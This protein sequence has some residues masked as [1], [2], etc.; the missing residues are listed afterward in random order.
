VVIEVTGLELI[1]AVMEGL[2]KQGV[3]VVLGERVVTWPA[4]PEHLDG[5]VKVLQTD[6]GRQFEADIVV[7]G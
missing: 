7:R 1:S 3:N 5:H 6:K 4:E 2:K